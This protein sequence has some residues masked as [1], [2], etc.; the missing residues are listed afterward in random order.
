LITL[1]SKI[2]RSLMKKWTY[3]NFLNLRGLRK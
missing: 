2:F 1:S 3:L